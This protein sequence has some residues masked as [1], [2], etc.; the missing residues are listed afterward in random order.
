[1]S[2]SMAQRSCAAGSKYT[3]TNPN[4]RIQRRKVQNRVNQRAHRC[5]SS[6]ATSSKASTKQR[7]YHVERWRLD[8]QEAT[9]VPSHMLEVHQTQP[10]KQH[11]S[12]RSHPGQQTDIYTHTRIEDSQTSFPA[13]TWFPLPSDQL[14][15]LIKYNVFRGLDQNKTLVESL[16][17][18]YL[19]PDTQDHGISQRPT[20]PSYTVIMSTSPDLSGSLAPTP[21]QMNVIHSTWINLL[22]FPTLRENLI[23]WEFSFDHV[24]LI[25]DLVGDLINVHIFSNTPSISMPGPVNPTR[26]VQLED[27]EPT[28]TQTGLIVWGEPHMAESW[29]ATP[30]FLRKWA[31]AVE[32]CRELMASTNYWRELRGEQPIVEVPSV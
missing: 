31:W 4:E 8:E 18:Q 2:K 10:G 27:D 26:V 20:Y 11:A 15:H 24:D 12:A 25:R 23:K 28:A 32:G 22:P 9:S 3:P 13:E 14:L 6:K 19:T 30:G 1:M 7:H 5:R 16:M 29:E 21:I 17:V